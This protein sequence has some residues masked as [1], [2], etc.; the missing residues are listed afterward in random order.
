MAEGSSRYFVCEIH[1]DARIRAIAEEASLRDRDLDEIEARLDSAAADPA[2]LAALALT[3]GRAG[4]SSSVHALTKLARRL[5]A[6]GHQAE[7]QVVALAEALLARRP[8]PEAVTRADAGYRFEGAPPLYVDDPLAAH[9][10]HRDKWGP[11]LR[12]DPAQ[13]HRLAGPDDT[14]GPLLQVVR[15]GGVVVVC[16]ERKPMVPPAPPLRIVLAGVSRDPGLRT[17][18]R[19]A[20]VTSVGTVRRWRRSHGAFEVT[21]DGVTVLPGKPR[22]PTAEV[23]ELMGRLLE[24]ARG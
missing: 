3:L 24:A 18:Q 17:L 8:D 21:G 14:A 22:L 15:D 16:F 19:W 10:H 6:A 7:A 1:E 2:E 11:P 4:R 9:W 12:P 13:L 20:R 5:E 23:V